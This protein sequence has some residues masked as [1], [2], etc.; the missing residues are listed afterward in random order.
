MTYEDV[1]KKL[2]NV[3]LPD[4]LLESHR[5]ELRVALIREYSLIKAQHARRSL[6]GW[7][8]SRSSL[9]RTVLVTSTIWVLIALVVVM[10]VLL[11]R[12]QTDSVTAIAVNTV[13]AS[14]EIKMALASDGVETVTVSDIGNNL[15]EVLV[16]SRG[17]TIIIVQVDTQNKKVTILEISYI[18][19][20]GS[21][22]EAEEY[23]T[24]AEQDKVIN[25][26]RTDHTFKDLMDKGASMSKTIAIWSI[27]STR[28]I[29]TDITTQTRERWS[30]VAVDYQDKQWF[31]LVNIERARVINRSATIV[32]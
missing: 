31:F 16:E 6:F 10:S 20:L 2:E 8:Q 24:G 12:Y 14:P 30:M 13:L 28:R 9:W 27:V 19:L 11:P 15:L 22:Y 1:I 5:R 21:P 32:P 4:I 25:L 23:I 29:D 26:A 18:I 3:T 17:G 7:L